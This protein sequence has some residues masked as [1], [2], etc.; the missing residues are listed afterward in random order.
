MVHAPESSVVFSD[1]QQVKNRR[2]LLAPSF[3]HQAV[4]NLEYTIQKKIDQLI[5]ILEDYHK[6]P[7]SSAVI[8]LAY[9]SLATDVIT[10]CCF[11][12][13]TKT[14]ADPNF[15]HP[16][17]VE[18]QNLLKRVWIQVYFPFIIHL[19]ATL[20]KTLILWLFP[21]FA[22]IMDV[23]ERFEQQVDSL[24]SN[25][26]ILSTSL[27]DTIYRHLLAPK[28]PEL[29]PSRTSLIHEAFTLIGA[30]T[31]TVEHVCTVGTFF[32]LQDCSIRRKLV[33]ELRDAWPDKGRPLTFTTLEKLPYLTAFIKESLRMAI[34][35][36]HPMPRIVGHETP[37]IAGLKIPPGTV[38]GMSPYFVHM[39]PEVFD[40]PFTF[41]PDR[42]LVENTSEMMFDLVPF[43]KG[44]RQW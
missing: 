33:E 37:E 29:R 42:W 20:P 19:L 32:A 28:D 43:G 5:T 26:D 3:S 30:G 9:R 15:S 2:S 36:V 21:A 34:G 4:M 18:S 13:S 40:D 17:A 6:S 38:V 35:A 10:D 12:N 31:D 16:L 14:L 27:H 44:P 39:N 1:S 22:T 23:Q 8:S 25:P 11:A 7:D 41:K 24:I